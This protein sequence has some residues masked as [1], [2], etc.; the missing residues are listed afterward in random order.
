MI[1]V[2]PAVLHRDTML[3]LLARIES[4]Y[5]PKKNGI[6]KNLI[7]PNSIAWTEY[8][9]YRVMGCLRRDFFLYHTYKLANN[10]PPNLYNGIWSSSQLESIKTNHEK[11]VDLFKRN[12]FVII[13]DGEVQISDQEIVD[14]MRPSLC[15][16]P[17]EF[18]VR[19][20]LV[21]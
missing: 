2:T 19:H 10:S 21:C 7:G 17:Q 1:G 8:S 5:G 20:L 4:L 16:F 9:A 11:T 3:S 15:P 6:L 18:T 12:V 14:F 13:Q